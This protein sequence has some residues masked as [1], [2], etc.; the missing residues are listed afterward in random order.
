M[1]EWLGGEP[2]LDEL[3]GDDMMSRVVASAGMSREEFRSRLA[4]V[5]NRIGIRAGQ[6]G[7]GENGKKPRRV[8]N[9]G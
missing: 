7:A 5:A 4:E 3:L 1:Q 6:S 8:A 9:R 2:T